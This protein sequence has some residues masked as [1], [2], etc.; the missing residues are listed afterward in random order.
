[1]DPKKCQIVVNDVLE[2]LN[3]ENKRLLEELLFADKCLKVLIEFKG[4][5][6]LNS[7]QFELNL[8]EK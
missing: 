4:F 8:D 1:M 6:E 7:N 2:E 3:E 5:V